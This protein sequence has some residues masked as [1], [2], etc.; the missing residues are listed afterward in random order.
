MDKPSVTIELKNLLLSKVAQLGGTAT[1]N[2][3]LPVIAKWKEKAWSDTVRWALIRMNEEGW[4][5][6]PFGKI[7]G[8][9]T[10]DRRDWLQTNRPKQKLKQQIWKITASGYQ[11]LNEAWMESAIITEEI[12]EVK[13][14][15]EGT[16]RT[17]TVNSYERNPEAR[18]KCIE[19]HG[20]TCT[21]CGFDFSRVYGAI[22]F[23]YIHVH[24]LKPLAEIKAQYQINPIEDLK[25]VCPNCHA[26]LHKKNPPFS[27]EE[28]QQIINKNKLHEC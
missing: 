11:R 26:M 1:T 15:V 9:N 25:P 21:A 4:L 3:L 17:I 19:H 28:L 13:N 8:G 6:C 22:G 16:V 2:D 18:R 7:N 10:K 20:Y 24:H 14:I 23:G 12:R 5:D 27:I